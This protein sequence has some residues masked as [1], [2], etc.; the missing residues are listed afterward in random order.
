VY[1]S[2][3]NVEE[4][5]GSKGMC[6]FQIKWV[7]DAKSTAYLTVQENGKGN[8]RGNTPSMPPL[9]KLL[10]VEYSRAHLECRFEHIY[11]RHLLPLANPSSCI[12]EPFSG[13][14]GPRSGILEPCLDSSSWLTRLP[15]SL[16]FTPV[17][18]GIKSGVWVPILRLECRGLEPVSFHAE[19][20]LKYHS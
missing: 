6:N 4:V 20:C 11:C 18:A 2:S 16:T 9:R 7:R 14:L 15:S 19:V 1:V 3:S 10:N 12:L 13:K 5:A 8:T 17:N